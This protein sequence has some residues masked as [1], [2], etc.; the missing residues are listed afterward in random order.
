MDRLRRWHSDGG[1]DDGIGR[2]DPVQARQWLD[3]QVIDDA[4]ACQLRNY[5]LGLNDGTD[6]SRLDNA[7]VKRQVAIALENGRLRTG[8][9]APVLLRPLGRVSV[10]AAAVA[11]PAPAP[12]PRA[13]P[14]APPPPV[15]TTFGSDLDVAAQVA[16]LVQAAR[17][18]VPFCE[19]CAK[20]AA[21]RAATE[22]TA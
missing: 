21:K 16:V 4:D 9:G 19:E 6:W 7:Q 1:A 3:R 18:G 8:A 5:A 17:D 13:A 20:A 14:V 2:L 22:A 12:S 15:E 10:P 11:A